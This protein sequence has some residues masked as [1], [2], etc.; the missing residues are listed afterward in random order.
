MRR[1]LSLFSAGL[2]VQSLSAVANAATSQ[3]IYQG[4][5]YVITTDA[6][7]GAVFGT[8]GNQSYSLNANRSLR[9]I[10]GVVNEKP[11]LLSYGKATRSVT[12]QLPCGTLLLNGFSTSLFGNI[13]GE[14]V[15]VNDL[16]NPEALPEALLDIAVGALLVDFPAVTQTSIKAFFIEQL[17]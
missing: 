15:T 17:R 4:K 1:L 12:G 3:G 9:F 6:S 10:S 2:L 11:V 16:V 14:T 8:W 7:T 13:C 5:A